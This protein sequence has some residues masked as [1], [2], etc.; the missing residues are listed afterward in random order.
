MPV[1]TLKSAV[2][3]DRREGS[4]VAQRVAAGFG[5]VGLRAALPFAELQEGGLTRQITDSG[6][7]PVGTLVDTARADR[8][9]VPVGN[10]GLAVYQL[11]PNGTANLKTILTAR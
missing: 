8:F 2:R 10:N 7:F 11:A 3:A 9:L 1:G 4:P 5:P 6:T